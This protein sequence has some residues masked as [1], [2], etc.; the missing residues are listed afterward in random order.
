MGDDA[1]PGCP[2][3]WGCQPERCS[4]DREGQ[5]KAYAKCGGEHEGTD[6]G[7]VHAVDHDIRKLE[8]DAA[9]ENGGVRRAERGYGE[10][11]GARKLAGKRGALPRVIGVRCYI[12]PR[13]LD[14]RAVKRPLQRRSGVDHDEV[15]ASRWECRA[16]EC[17]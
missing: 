16:D 6:G 10:E 4:W 2:L 17:L 3:K 7:V 8:L 9:G 12:D 5:G 1:R 15:S 13:D 11:R 14:K